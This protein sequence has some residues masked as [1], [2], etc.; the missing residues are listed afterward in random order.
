M[1][2][3]AEDHKRIAAG[4][5][6]TLCRRRGPVHCDGAKGFFGYREG[7]RLIVSLSYSGVP[8]HSDRHQ[9]KFCMFAAFRLC[10]L[11]TGRNIVPQHFSISHHRSGATSEMAR[12][13]RAR[14]SVPPSD[15]TIIFQDTIL[16][17]RRCDA[18]VAPTA[19]I[20]TPVASLSQCPRCAW[21]SS[22]RIGS[23]G[24]TNRAAPILCENCKF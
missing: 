18:E 20:K 23:V 24:A 10:R 14:G 8:R 5:L 2:A 7:N 9:I 22:D 1:P 15:V 21:G 6:N 11:L 13:G 12:F 17:R 3:L 4:A 19:V 16:R